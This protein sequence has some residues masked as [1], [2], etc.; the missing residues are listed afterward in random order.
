MTPS[1]VVELTWSNDVHVERVRLLH[2]PDDDH[3]MPAAE[4]FAVACA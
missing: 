4:S 2:P 3:V 1:I